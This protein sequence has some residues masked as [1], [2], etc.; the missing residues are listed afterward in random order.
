MALFSRVLVPLYHSV[1]A[2]GFSRENEKQAFSVDFKDGHVDFE[3]WSRARC[4]QGNPSR[5]LAG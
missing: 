2:N 4:S 3:V 1:N 5:D